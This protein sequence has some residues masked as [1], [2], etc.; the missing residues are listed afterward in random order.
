MFYTFFSLLGNMSVFKMKLGKLTWNTVMFRLH[1]F[2]DSFLKNRNWV[3]TIKLGTVSL[4]PIFRRLLK[5]T[6]ICTVI[7]NC[8]IKK[9][10]N[11]PLLFT[12]SIYFFKLHI[13]K[14]VQILPLNYT[15]FVQFINKPYLFIAVFMNAWSCSFRPGTPFTYKNWVFHILLHESIN[16]KTLKEQLP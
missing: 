1:N 8:Q 10:L 3:G 14:A 9:K 4:F 12:E 5:I 2:P 15:H 7:H 11:K 16:R 6:K 13:G